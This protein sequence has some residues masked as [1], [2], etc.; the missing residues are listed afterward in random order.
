MKNL[1]WVVNNARL[2]LFPWV[3]VKNLASHVLGQLARRLQEDWEARWGYRPVLMETFVDPARYSGVSYRAAG[4]RL[5]G[6][7]T[8][9]GICRPNRQYSTTPKLLFVRPLADDFR[10]QLCSET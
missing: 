6:K 1:P 4:W 3:L 8:G 7:T 2:L 10:V 5:L 9:R